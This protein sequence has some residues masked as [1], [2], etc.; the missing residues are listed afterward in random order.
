MT[1]EAKPPLP[2]I[3]YCHETML[4]SIGRDIFSF[5]TFAAMIGLGVLCHSSAMQWVGSICFLLVMIGRGNAR[6]KKMTP[7]EIRV[8]LDRLEAVGTPHG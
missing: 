5:V 6:L 1:T 8:D 4:Q 2:V 3:Y 7:A